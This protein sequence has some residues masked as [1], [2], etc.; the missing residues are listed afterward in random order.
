MKR[1]AMYLKESK[2]ERFIREYAE[3]ERENDVI[4]LKS[5]NL[6]ENVILPFYLCS[7]DDWQC[8][9][10]TQ[11]FLCFSMLPILQ[12]QVLFYTSKYFI[13]SVL[14]G[15]MVAPRKMCPHLS[16]VIYAYDHILQNKK[17]FN[18]QLLI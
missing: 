8:M 9:K 1:E 10:L 3:K 2:N 16:I 14:V 12:R 11:R 13:Y 7:F 17:T 4:L 6:K 5:E 18:L 15:L